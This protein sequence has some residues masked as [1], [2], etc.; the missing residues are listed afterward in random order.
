VKKYFVLPIALLYL[1]GISYADTSHVPE[2]EVHKIWI[3]F[4][5]QLLGLLFGG[6]QIMRSSLSRQ[7]DIIR[8]EITNMKEGIERDIKEIKETQKTLVTKDICDNR[9]ELEDVAFSNIKDK[10]ENL[11]KT[12]QAC[13]HKSKE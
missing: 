4:I 9:K 12:F 11:S 7:E 10:I 8:R 2:S 6:W 3:A 1:W 5:G 13:P